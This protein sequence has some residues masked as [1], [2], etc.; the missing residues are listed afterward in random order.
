MNKFKP[1]S[2]LRILAI[3][4]CAL[5]VIGMT[6]GTVFHF[7]GNG[8]F[9]YD[10]EY[11]SY[12]SISV[13]YLVIEINSGDEKLDIEAVCETAFENAG[14]KYYLKKTD[15]NSRSNG[16]QVEYLFKCSTDS[17]AM[18]SAKDAINK[19]IAEL[20][21]FKDGINPQSRASVHEQ[22][23][24]VGGGHVASMAAI[25]VATIVV[26]QLLYTML[27]Y[28]FSAAFTAIVV[29]L[30]NLAL[31]AAL[32]ALCRV[33]VSSA[34]MVFAV[35]L[36]LATAIG[37]T[38]M[39]ERVKRNA[40]E[41]AKLSVEEVT[42]LSAAQTLKINVA[43]SACLAVAAVLLFAVMAVSVMSLA[44]VLTPACLAVVAFIVAIYGT[45]LCA[46]AIYCFIKT[47]GNKI[48]AKPSQKK[49]N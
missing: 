41:E 13:S 25:V 4:S 26:V 33:P 30:H 15:S 35:I 11:A 22:Q 14:I 45:V 6:L 16:G 9:N 48:I 42:N 2:K 44:S 40:K 37:V 20:P 36:T 49:G 46:P 39:L 17:K 7:I 23:T 24:I 18:N 3:I 27:R 8:F 47:I 38:Y 34:V 21:I 32:L 19:K 1:A 43:L 29:D 5:I 10:G 28:R 12:K 31:Y